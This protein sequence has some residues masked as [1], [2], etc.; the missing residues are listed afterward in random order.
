MLKRLFERQDTTS[1]RAG[2]DEA[3]SK[4]Q[5]LSSTISQVT[6]ISFYKGHVEHGY[7][8]DNVPTAQE[9][10]R[11][12]APTQQYYANWIYATQIAPRVMFAP[13]G[14]FCTKCPTVIVDENVIQAGIKRKFRFQGILGLEYEGKKEPDL[15]RTWNAQEAVYIFDENQTAV[16]LSTLGPK[17]SRSLRRTKSTGSQRRGATKQSGKRKRRR[18]K[19]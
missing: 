4:E 7:S 13:A 12:H 3:Q 16:V 19:R 10:P 2:Q 8:V 9:C 6:G 5:G 14:R 11:C 17:T 15:F 1:A 18:K